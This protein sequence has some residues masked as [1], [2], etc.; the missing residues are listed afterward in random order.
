[1]KEIHTVT[2]LTLDYNPG[3]DDTVVLRSRC[4]GYFP[5]LQDAIRC[6][7][8]NWG[9]LY[10]HGHYTHAVIE[11]VKPGIYQYPR[12]ELWH[13]WNKEKKGYQLTGKPEGLSNLVGFSI[14]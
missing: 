9:D 10:E 8:E 6:I 7:T 14:G 11:T 5:D 3:L 13:R 2:T 1:M 4:V 12:S